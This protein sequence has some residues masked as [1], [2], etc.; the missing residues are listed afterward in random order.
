MIAGRDTLEES[1]E[2]VLQ[3]RTFRNAPS[4]RRLLKYL[5]DHAAAD[6]A[7]RLKEYTIGV[8]AFSKPPDYDPRTDSTVRIQVG[9]LRQKLADY[10]KSD[11]RDDR[12]VLSLPKGRFSL[13]CAPRPDGFEPSDLADD[14]SETASEVL[15]TTEADRWRLATF[16]LAALLVLTVL[17][18]YA[19]HHRQLKD[20]A[21]TPELSQL[22]DPLLESGKPLIIA[23]G[24]PLFVEFG[25]DPIFET[26]D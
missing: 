7:D 3:S 9:R 21:W 10:Y 1:V 13:V 8:D 22:W 26:V 6:D 14:D 18:G 19:L 4:S 16:V 11:G 5:S 24:N 17:A 15:V 2:R 23:V 12:S 25:V 20:A